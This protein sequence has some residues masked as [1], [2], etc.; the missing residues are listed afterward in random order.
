[1]NTVWKLIKQ[2]LQTLILVSFIYLAH[3]SPPAPTP[4]RA[5][6]PSKVVHMQ[7]PVSSSL[8]APWAFLEGMAPSPVALIKHLLLN[9]YK[10]SHLISYTL[11][12]KKTTGSIQLLKSPQKWN[13]NWIS[14]FTKMQLLFPLL[15]SNKNI[16]EKRAFF[17]HSRL[18][19]QASGNIKDITYLISVVCQDHQ[20][21]CHLRLASKNI[22]F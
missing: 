11:K 1:M 22:C 5:T 21:H 2:G 12:K 13:L 3:P 17:Q 9:T 7:W 19:R 20:C 15:L 6:I 4:D 14:K 10:F 16:K 18:P 8:S